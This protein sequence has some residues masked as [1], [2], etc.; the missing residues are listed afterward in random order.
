MTLSTQ[1]I[2]HSS[3]YRSLFQANSSSPHE[4]DPTEVN[5]TTVSEY[6][7]LLW[8]LWQQSEWRWEKR[9]EGGRERGRKEENE[10]EVEYVYMYMY[11]YNPPCSLEWYCTA[12][13][14]FDV[15]QTM[16]QSLE[17]PLVF[18]WAPIYS[19]FWENSCRQMSESPT[20]FWCWSV[21]G[22]RE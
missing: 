5:E 1:H 14:S 16:Q 7:G 6:V 21:S 2:A 9:R 10:R 12:L 15:A 18:W 22:Q 3:T 19:T 11:I 20:S 17:I 4:G 8:Y 13:F